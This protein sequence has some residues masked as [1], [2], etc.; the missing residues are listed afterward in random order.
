[1]SYGYILT[2]PKWGYCAIAPAE[3]RCAMWSERRD[4]AH[5]FLSLEAANRALSGWA[6]GLA[7]IER[8]RTETVNGELRVV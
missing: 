1:M 6:P 2:S 5:L 3:G 4:R 8:C 7:A